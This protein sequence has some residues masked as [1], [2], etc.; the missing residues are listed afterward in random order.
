MKNAGPVS[1]GTGPA[2]VSAKLD[3]FDYLTMYFLPFMM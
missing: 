3:R 1:F 2:Q